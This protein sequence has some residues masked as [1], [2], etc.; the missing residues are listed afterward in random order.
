MSAY[1]VPAIDMLRKGRVSSRQNRM[2]SEMSRG[3]QQYFP[4]IPNR[5]SSAVRMD[6]N[7]V[8]PS[9][10]VQMDLSRICFFLLA[11]VKEMPTIEKKPYNVELLGDQG[12][13]KPRTPDDILSQGGSKVVY[14][15]HENGDEWHPILAS[16]GEQK[17]ITCRCK[18]SRSYSEIKLCWC[19]IAREYG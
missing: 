18:V 14:T 2:L 13:E 3:K 12:S 7:H 8:T 4:R 1:T 19:Q 16:H 17:C 5:C 6:V 9:N 11:Q 15:I 10:P